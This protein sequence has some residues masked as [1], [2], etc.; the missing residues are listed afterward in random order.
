MDNTVKNHKLLLRAALFL[1]VLAIA[2]YHLQGI[3]AYDDLYT[4]EDR[5][6]FETEKRGRLDGVY[7]GGS[8][9][10]S[11]WQPLFGW[12]DHGI[13]IENWCANSMR[14][15]A[16]QYFIEEARK[17]QPDALF[18]LNLNTFKAQKTRGLAPENIHRAVDYWPLS[19]NAIRLIHAMC[20][21]SDITGLDRLEFYLPII[22][23]HSGWDQ[24]DAYAFGTLDE[25]YRTSFHGS[26]FMSGVKDISDHYAIY[27][28]PKPVSD[29][30]RSIFGDLLDYCGEN[31]L[32]VL[33]VKVPQ[34]LDAN[35]Q[36]YLLTLQQM[37][38]E[39]GYPCLDLFD[40]IDALGMD[41]RQQWLNDDHTNI[42]GSL[43]VSKAIGDYLVEHY[44]FE[45]KR[46]L[47]AWA[48]WDASADAYME[49]VKKYTL[50]FER[51]HA[52]RIITDIPVLNEPEVS[53]QS[54]RLSWK[55][56]D[57]ADGFII[58]RRCNSGD[59]MGWY[60]VGEAGA[61]AREWLD[62]DLARRKRYT[63]TVVPY[64]ALEGET[65]YGAFDA[66]GITAKTE[67]NIG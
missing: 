45:D 50:P 37:A 5:T 24:L 27:D 44:G 46:G 31:N 4:Y 35:H 10:F 23:F 42:H 61:Q 28:K 13:A 6:V 33:F 51:D 63:Y 8:D 36:G 9:V 21:R 20:E 16:V 58:C 18:I 38:E 55:Y 11:Y 14:A 7:I 15:V 25:N 62:D 29:D 26:S 60:E 39:R 40:Q 67:E 17:R 32:K 12:R 2:V 54:L 22:R 57:Q 34:A 41:L 66:R 59:D 48:D 3:F 47:P 43:T 1:V 30:M 64:V 19:L 53:G 56:D 52:K 65:V 49:I